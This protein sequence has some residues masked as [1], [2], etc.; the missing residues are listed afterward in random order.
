VKWEQGRR[1]PGDLVTWGRVI[2]GIMRTW[3]L[4][5]MDNKEMES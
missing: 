2:S 4:E 3:D 1:K 5:D